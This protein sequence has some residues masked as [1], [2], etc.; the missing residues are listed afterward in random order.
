MTGEHQITFFHDGKIKT[1]G[2]L[3]AFDLP[4]QSTGEYQRPLPEF[5]EVCRE[6]D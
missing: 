6:H 3:D 2:D 1:W 4:D 5:V